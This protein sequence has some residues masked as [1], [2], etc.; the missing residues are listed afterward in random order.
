MTSEISLKVLLVDDDSNIRRT[1]LL[2]IK[3]MNCVVD[4]AASVAEA[5]TLI[6]STEYDLVLTD[7]K[8]AEQTGLDLI[9]KTK[10]L[11]PDVP[12]VVMTAFA[13]YEN[14]V[15]VV[16]EGAFDYLPKPFTNMQ[17]FQII[18]RIRE[19]ISLRR[20]TLQDQPI[21]TIE[22]MEKNLITRVLKMESNQEKAAE[23]LGITKVTLWRKRK[24]YDLP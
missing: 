13:S 17:L 20:A 3:D 21:C 1:L 5:M 8:M 6:A 22:E 9:K 15:S 14:A 24:Q 23:I 12:I 2:S 16:K 19:I 18:H 7:F 4:Q 11:R 10:A